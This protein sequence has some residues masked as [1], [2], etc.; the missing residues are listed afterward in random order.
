MKSQILLAISAACLLA[1]CSPANDQ[2]NAAHTAALPDECVNHPLLA[3][4]PAQEPLSGKQ[5]TSISCQPY[6]IEMVW[7]DEYTPTTIS[8]IDSQGPDGDLPPALAQ[9]ARTMPVEAARTALIMSKGVRETALAYPTSLE[10]LGGEDYLSLYKE[11]AN[12]LKYSLDVEP[13]DAGGKVGTLLGLYKE[14]YLLTI[15]SGNYDI[16]GIS[17]GEAAYAPLLASVN[18]SVLP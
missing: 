11:E 10:S 14:R 9:A 17:A 12:G 2:G 18:L 4:M 1:A 7:G 6:S 16:V 13:K 5:F 8:L 3:A 15:N